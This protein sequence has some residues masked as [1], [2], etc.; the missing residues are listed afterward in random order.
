VTCHA[1][2]PGPELYHLPTDPEERRN[3]VADHPEVARGPRA[4]VEAL[5]GRD[6]PARFR[7]NADSG[8]APIVEYLGATGQRVGTL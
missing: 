5:P 3:V 7:E 6:L 8:P 1:D 2:D 4:H